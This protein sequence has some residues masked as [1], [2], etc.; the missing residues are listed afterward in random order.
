V[1]QDTR[2]NG[3]S[4]SRDHPR[5]PQGNASR[6]TT[7]GYPNRPKEASS[8][9]PNKVS[10]MIKLTEPPRKPGANEPSLVLGRKEVRLLGMGDHAAGAYPPPNTNSSGRATQTY[11]CKASE[12]SNLIYV[13]VDAIVFPAKKPL[14]ADLANYNLSFE[15][16]HTMESSMSGPVGHWPK[17]CH[18]EKNSATPASPRSGP[19][20]PSHSPASLSLTDWVLTL[21]AATLATRVRA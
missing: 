9:C 11:N 4:S 20:S 16:L 18:G 14:Y 10:P 1:H 3:R 12:I 7:L 2:T 19:Q 5:G 21:R 17:M 13:V 15:H 6:Y 8:A